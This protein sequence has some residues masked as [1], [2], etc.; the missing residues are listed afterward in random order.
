MVLLL[1]DLE[2]EH[3]D[4]KLCECVAVDPLSI[5]SSKHNWTKYWPPLICNT[6]ATINYLVKANNAKFHVINSTIGLIH[7]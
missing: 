7:S 4:S 1:L 5:S 2:H 6:F 3:E